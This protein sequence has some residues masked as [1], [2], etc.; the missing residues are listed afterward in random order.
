M[1]EQISFNPNIRPEDV[2]PQAGMAE[3]SIAASAEMIVTGLE[4]ELNIKRSDKLMKD[5]KIDFKDLEQYVQKLTEATFIAPIKKQDS[6]KN[7][8]DK[9]E[10]KK[11]Q[12]QNKKKKASKNLTFAFDWLPRKAAPPKKVTL[13]TGTIDSFSSKVDGKALKD[14]AAAYTGDTLNIGQKDGINFH[15]KRATLES[16]FEKMGVPQSF[17]NTAHSE[18]NAALK[19]SLTRDIK[20]AVLSRI[21]SSSSLSQWLLES[22]RS[23]NLLNFVFSNEI[24]RGAKKTASKG[25][26]GRILRRKLIRDWNVKEIEL[27]E[28]IEL[29]KELGLDLS[30]WHSD[31][32]EQRVLLD[33]DGNL[34]I[35][36]SVVEAEWRKGLLFDDYK[37]VLITLLLESSALVRILLNYR[38]KKLKSALIDLGATEA[39]VSECAL[40]ARKVAWAK[41]V[42]TLKEAHLSRVFS[43]SESEFSKLSSKINLL[44]KEARRIGTDISREGVKFVEARLE[45]MA[46]ETASYKIEFLRSMQTLGY[47]KNAER[48]LKWLTTTIERLKEKEERIELFERIEKFVT[49]I[50]KS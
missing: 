21:S 18:L 42:T 4:K 5:Q 41:V 31:F 26:V 48:D 8:D 45:L 43:R 32:L 10:P 37:F 15:L 24:I 49:W 13:K 11:D 29:A 30:K 23:A 16:T 3:E 28:L 47:D 17:M 36:S 39:E 19:L 9:E 7:E 14:Y 33:A 6:R 22:K 25:L 44:T 46:L 2:K 38:L 1:A 12:A 34:V 50:F 40:Q 27:A 35:D 20:T